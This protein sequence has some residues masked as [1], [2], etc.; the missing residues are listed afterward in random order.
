M[1][2]LRALFSRH[3]PFRYKVVVLVAALYGISPIDLIPD[4]A[5][6]L[7]LMD[8]ALFIIG[9]LAWFWN[10]TKSVRAKLSAKTD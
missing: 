1:T 7:G 3:I 2:L 10:S 4:I 6:V 8:D 9:A 5:P